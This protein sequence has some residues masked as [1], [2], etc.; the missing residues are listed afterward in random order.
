MR[1]WGRRARPPG[2][3]ARAASS[4]TTRR[5][6]RP[7]RPRPVSPPSLGGTCG[8]GLGPGAPLFNIIRIE[9]TRGGWDG[10]GAR[11]RLV[12]CDPFA[13][14]HAASIYKPR[15]FLR[16]ALPA[17]APHSVPRPDPNGPAAEV[18]GLGFFCHSLSTQQDGDSLGF[19]TSFLHPLT[20]FW[21]QTEDHDHSR[22]DR[23]AKLSPLSGPPPLP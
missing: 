5:L 11:R 20:L 17:I 9:T 8:G 3:L 22:A 14:T 18:V 10:L 15:S 12:V 13:P 7:A 21:F 1:R 19:P 6:S 4:P 2:V 16:T 23:A